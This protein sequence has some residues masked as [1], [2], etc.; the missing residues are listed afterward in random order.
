MTLNNKP[1]IY[2]LFEAQV[3]EHPDAEA[4]DFGKSQITYRKLDRK[5]RQIAHKLRENN[6]TAGEAAAIYYQSPLEMVTGVMG[7]IKAGGIYLLIN[8]TDPPGYNNYILNHS[9]AKYMVTYSHDHNIDNR[10]VKFNGKT[11]SL[12][13]FDEDYHKKTLPNTGTREGLKPQDPV[14]LYYSSGAA[15][16]PGGITLSHQNL[17]NWVI[18][19]IEKL[20]IDFS[21]TLF[22]TSSRVEMLFPIWLVNLVCGG[23][24]HFFEPGGENND[25]DRKQG[26]KS[27]ICSL[28]FLQELNSTNT[29]KEVLPPGLSNIVSIGEERFNAGE[30]K[31]FLKEKKIRWHNYYGFPGIKMITTLL[32]SGPGPGGE[33]KHLGRP[34]SASHVYILDSSRNPVSIGV[35]GEL[36]VSGNAA[37]GGYFKNDRLNQSHFLENPFIPGTTIFKTG[38]QGYW[39]GDGKIY[40]T[41]RGDGIVN[42]NGVGISATEVESVLCQHPQVIDCAV[43]P[44]ENRLTAFVVL[45]ESP[46]DVEENHLNRFLGNYLFKDILP[47]GFVRL[48]SLPRNSDGLLDRQHLEEPA[49]PDS[50]QVKSLEKEMER[51][52]GIQ[53]AVIINNEK[54]D[55]LPALHLKDFLPVFP[56]SVETGREI[57]PGFE[58]KP[59]PLEMPLALVHGGEFK[60][61]EHDPKTLVEILERAAVQH[62]HNG[63]TYIQPDGTGYF[64]SYPD[65]LERSESILTGLK[66]QGL[67][68]GD[69]VILQLDRNEDYLAAFWGCT[70]GGMV[71]VPVPVPRL[72]T[73]DSSEVKTLQRIR[74]LLD[75]PIIVGE[76]NLSRSMASL[77]SDFK[78]VGL[79]E[80]EA[81]SPCGI[82][83]KSDPGDTALLLFT[84]GSTGI[85]KGV[86]LCH[87]SIL[88]R[89]KAAIEFCRLTADEVSLNWLPLEHVVG[90]LMYHIKQVYLGCR[91]VQVK[92]D[93]IL[94]D[95]LRWVDLMSTYKVTLTFGPNF[96]YSLLNT[97]FKQ[98]ISSSH[99][100]SPNW[101]LSRLKIVNVGAEPIDARTMK[102]FLKLFIPFGLPKTAVHPS[103]GMS[104]TSSGVV[105]SKNFSLD[106][107]EGIH[108]LAQH[109]PNQ[110]LLRGVQGVPRHG[111]PIRDGFVAEDVID[112]ST[113]TCNLHLSPLAEKSPPNRVPAPRARRRQKSADFVE[114]GQPF[115]GVSLRIVDSQGQVTGEGV[116][117]RLQIKGTT[118]FS[119]YYKNPGINREVFTP[120]GWFDTG[121][122]AFIHNK[123][124]TITGRDKD[125]IIIN[126]INYSNSEI[127]AVVE[128]LEDI[129]ISFTAACAVR[130]PGDV[131]DKLAIFYSSTLPGFPSILDQVKQINR[132][133]AGK[134][135]IQAD[136]IIPVQRDEIPKTSIG[137]IQRSRLAKLFTAG[138]FNDTLEK[139][140]IALGNE[141]T[142][143]AWFFNREWHRK[144]LSSRWDQSTVHGNT[145]LVF[146]EEADLADELVLKLKTYNCQCIRIKSAGGFKKKNPYDYEIDSREPEDYQRLFA[147]LHQE[148]TRANDIFHLLGYRGGNSEVIEEAQARSVFSLLYLTRSCGSGSHPSQPLV[149][150]FVVTSH[151]QPVGNHGI[152]YGK[153][154]V[155]GFLQCASLERPGMWFRHIDLEMALLPAV[156]AQYIINEWENPGKDLE[157]AYRNGFRMVPYLAPL[158]MKPRSPGKFPLKKGGIYLVTGGLGGIGVHVCLWLI[159]RFRAKLIIVGRTAL[160]PK[161]EWEKLFRED[162]IIAQRVRRYRDIESSGGEFIYEPGDVGDET[163]VQ[164]LINK[165]ELTWA[166]PIS[167]IF[168]L[169]GM[170]NPKGQWDQ[171]PGVFDAMYQSKVYGTLNLHRLFQ[172]RPALMFAVFSSTISLFGAASYSAYAAANS[173]LDGFCHYRLRGG[174]P[175]TFCLNWSSWENTGMSEG[176]P[177]AVKEALR[178]KGYE[179]ITPGQGLNSLLVVL[180]AQPGQYIIGINGTHQHIR[181]LLKRYPPGKQVVNVYY[182]LKNRN[183]SPDPGIHRR[184]AAILAARYKRIDAVME[185]HKIET[186]PMNQGVI[187]YRQLQRQGKGHLKSSIV[188]LDSPGTEVEKKLVKLWQE[189]LGKERIGIDDHFFELGGHSLKAIMLAAKIHKEFDIKVSLAE[190]FQAP[191]IR[192]FAQYMEGL[193]KI[194]YSTIEAVEEKEYYRLSS[195]QKRMYIV[196]HMALDKTGYNMPQSFILEGETD[197]PALGQVFKKLVLRHQVLRTSFKIVNGEPVQE[198]HKKVEFDIEYF[199]Q[200]TREGTGGLAP[201]PQESAAALISSFLGPFDLSQAPLLRVRLIKTGQKQHILMVDMHHIVS[202]GV[203][204]QLLIKDFAALYNSEEVPLLKLQYKDYAAWQHKE[205]QKQSLK[206]QENYWLKAFEQEVPIPGIPTDYPRPAIQ[207][208]AGS[209]IS[210]ELSS[211]KTS[212]LNK[213]AREENS[214]LFMILL[215]TY[216]I[217]L[218]KICG[219]DDIVIGTPVAGR[220]HTDL[221]QIMGMFVNTLALRN[222]PRGEQTVA[223]FLEE[224][225]KTTLEA[226]E[227]QDYQFEELVDKISINRDLSHNPLFDTIFALQNVSRQE[228]DFPGLKIKPYIQQ[229]QT[230]KFDLTLSGLESEDSL[231]FVLEY[232][233]KL[234][235]EETIK[236]FSAY[237]DHI[238]SCV[239]KGIEQKI[240]SLELI[241]GE[242]K[243]KILLEYNATGTGYPKD[244]TIHE[245][246]ADQVERTPD[247]IAVIGQSVGAI[248]ELPLQITYNQLNKK[249]GQLAHLLLEKGVQ[250]DTIV[251]IMLERSIEMI[252]GI[253]G[254]LKAGG[255]Y[256]PIDPGYPQERINYM[257]T[258]SAAK[259]LV[260]APALSGKFEKLS[261]VNCQLLMVNEKPSN[262]RRLN[263]PPQEA[264]LIN[265]YQ[266]AINNL[267]LEQ[268]SL[269]YVIY[270]SG[271]TGKPKGT[272]TTHYNVIRVVRD[273]NYIEF[274]SYDRVLQ[275][276]NYAFDGSVF[277]IYGAL[278]NGAVLVT[279]QPEEVMDVHRLA[280]VIAGEA[281]TVFFLTTA[282][283]NALVDIKPGSLRHIRKIL[284]GGERVSLEHSKRAR[285]YLGKHRVIHVY[286]PT[287]STVYATY[288]FIDEIDRTWYT[289]PIGK[290]IANTAVYILDQWMQSVPTGIYGEL[291][292]GGDGLA[293]GYLNN[294]ELTKE[295]FKRAVISHSSLVIVS[296]LKT[297][298]NSSKLSTNDRPSQYTHPPLPHHPNSP[299]SQYPITPSPHHPIYRTGDLVRWLVDGNIEFLGR[300]DSQVKIRGF[301]VEMAEI[302]SHLLNYEKVKEAFVTVIE[303]EEGDKLICAYVAADSD[304]ANGHSPGELKKY[305]SHMLPD[306]MIPAYFLFL[307][308]LPLNSSGKV[309]RGALP[310]P[311]LTAGERY[312]TPADVFEVKLVRIWSDILRIKEDV[313]GVYDDF[314][315]LGGHSLKATLLAAQ[316]SKTFNVEFPLTTVF[317]RPTVR[318]MADVVRRSRISIYEEIKTIEKKEYYPLSSAQ[319][320]IFFLEQFENIGITYNIASVL[321]VE[322]K[323]DLKQLEHALAAMLRRHETL[324]TSFHLINNEPVQIVHDVVNYKMEYYN[325]DDSPWPIIKDFIRPFDLSSAPLFHVGIVSLS[326]EAYLLLYDIHHIIGD[327]T[328][329]GILTD[330]F[331]A[332][333]NGEELTPLTLQYKDFSAWQNNLFKTGNIEKQAAYWLERFSGEIPVLNLPTDHPRPGSLSF[334]G[335]TIGASLAEETALGLKQFCLE[336]GVTLYMNLLAALNVLF[337]K[338]TNQG[339][340]V[341]GTGIMGRPHADLHWLIGM[342]VNSLAIRN[343]P[344]GKKQYADFLQEVKETCLK[345]FENQ[346]V[347]FEWL[348]DRL[349]IK[350]DP[351]RN[352]LFDVILMV[353]NFE[354]AKGSDNKRYTSPGQIKFSP[355]P[356][357]NKTSKFDLNFTAWEIENTVKFNL[358]Y[359]STM[360]EPSTARKI[361]SDYLD[362]LGQLIKNRDA[363]LEDAAISYGFQEAG[364]AGLD[365]EDSEFGF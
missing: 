178:R 350:R 140:D 33:F 274:S 50:I 71:P 164:K 239:L 294:P 136:Y 283:F 155:P 40:F 54:T 215:A 304:F 226:F 305:L 162:H 307:E 214:T 221:E 212:A 311:Q 29:Y 4:A 218:A 237:F 28:A 276:S 194:K 351:S 109:S 187:D 191:C 195:A 322:G 114:I 362:I 192:E 144:A 70:L 171:D 264:N 365:G 78:C 160:P 235:K 170:G 10:K 165:A 41:G 111:G 45:G 259:I 236:R 185:F 176:N 139:I 316:V 289:I 133:I 208:F 15:G 17:F 225:K 189:V 181:P 83:Y 60:E 153:C 229:S 130:D 219:Q 72:M 122:L 175:N 335:K 97:K 48:S 353:Q 326:Q 202:D 42:I 233:T 73:R 98:F 2:D 1:F 217:F 220:R 272:L 313:I 318:E 16:K 134:I 266:L 336:S 363:R 121:D 287:E 67:E 242:E 288:Y 58:E 340:I 260:S 128:E 343:F 172:D 346:D 95:P 137:K 257:L 131:T 19:N 193:G 107:T 347:Q 89:E 11:L 285:E 179:L 205:K 39:Q 69:K 310:C 356:I 230:A 166:Q 141:N 306:Y 321:K 323:L 117:G 87:R 157:V 146:Q 358:E 183:N 64:Q 21:Q 74:E 357:E 92:N 320:R 35:N 148:G 115:P 324:S 238:V 317:T 348:V 203:S 245:L 158:D 281:I 273:T 190:I 301:R 100:T 295:K 200:E 292:I 364:A 262:R 361:L 327:G 120:D 13:N 32:E 84:S 52:P 271:T 309:D 243:K 206:Q 93:Y 198:I 293:R 59:L 210:F 249:S 344:D 90:L 232:S 147:A 303:K 3:K 248:H 43:T 112:N 77:F 211:E 302:E 360:F 255:A 55:P 332:F 345:A 127:E 174:Y 80:L 56:G 88:A 338:Y 252:V 270:T 163:F 196:Q 180:H 265:D 44:R 282:L 135:G 24:I 14:F 246:F 251:G 27:L 47:I 57:E 342:F 277:D 339:D 314:F 68:P 199:N 284:F 36:Y 106:S 182:T 177:P 352:P 53:H 201:L 99:T 341:V 38:Y 256:L 224:V 298:D 328:S 20:K 49:I 116:V 168:H 349:Q 51:I 85:P 204:H 61:E 26:I 159:T 308:K 297:I 337:Y 9:Q 280:E 329:M 359:A 65:L 125:V 250:P 354:P 267:Q 46:G 62:G 145:C 209:A 63:L 223:E 186:M 331:A 102:E 156:N 113:Y 129:A 222:Y 234:F 30:F 22:V 82:H 300:V 296:F 315:E 149:R 118:L 76:E 104:E 268:A 216:S 23:K 34:V 263:N 151:T 258:D 110:R 291:Y 290:A 7:V 244:K 355:Y 124:L 138:F 75:N 8:P 150:V 5:A 240:S 330:D 184:M 207:T 261:I 213:I 12:D 275:L 254:I 66:N 227:N 312:E 25:P 96:A 37:P 152:D 126:G 169:A 231:V 325:C 91:Q 143:P 132:A 269:A 334:E 101:D 81:D 241:P 123:R 188:E 247:R 108:L 319:K 253:M 161:E 105:Y 167:G 6:F 119:G 86:Q 18:F 31:S 299:S 279:M 197:V 333:Y 142:V 286:G 94:S 79:R 278:L 154:G 228:P 173:F 103:W